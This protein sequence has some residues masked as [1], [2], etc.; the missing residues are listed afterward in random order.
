MGTFDDGSADK[1]CSVHWTGTR[2][3]GSLIRCIA[4]RDSVYR[5]LAV[6]AHIIACA[7][8]GDVRPRF[9]SLGNAF[10]FL[11]EGL[12]EVQTVS[13]LFTCTRIIDVR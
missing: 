11:P 2:D 12:R 13:H 10:C 9:L 1:L 8:F 6:I 5:F 4:L 7:F 3:C